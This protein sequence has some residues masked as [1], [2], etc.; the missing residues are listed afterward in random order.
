MLHKDGDLT[1][2]GTEIDAIII[3]LLLEEKDKYTLLTSGFD[4][5]YTYF[6]AKVCGYCF[7][8]SKFAQSK[9][10]E[11][12]HL[13]LNAEKLAVTV[14]VC[15]KEQNALYSKCGARL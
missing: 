9:N 10:L 4:G 13:R 11:G 12:F 6:A 14:D 1:I 5:F 2:R 15:T 3:G 7:G 8:S